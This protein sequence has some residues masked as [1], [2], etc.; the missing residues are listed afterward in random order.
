MSWI[1][2]TGEAGVFGPDECGNRTSEG[3]VVTWGPA[4]RKD[5]DV[6]RWRWTVL[7]RRSEVFEGDPNGGSSDGNRQIVDI[8]E[9]IVQTR[10]VDTDKRPPSFGE[11]PGFLAS[12]DD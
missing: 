3:H 9:D 7:F 4:T 8:E 12:R 6:G 2:D 11:T 10:R 5:D 1:L